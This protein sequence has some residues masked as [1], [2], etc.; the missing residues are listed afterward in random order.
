MSASH[1]SFPIFLQ[2]PSITMSRATTLLFAAAAVAISAIPSS[3]AA[4][5]TLTESYAPNDFLSTSKWS[6]WTDA[7]P[8]NGLVTYQSASNAQSKNLT[9]V[10]ND[11]FYM[12]VDTTQQQLEGRP[13]VRIQSV[14][15][16]SDGIYV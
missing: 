8:T 14:T 2:H 1:P 15:N 16:Y 9:G 5:W 10:S 7:D 11:E 12:R 3:R 13:S 6:Y 4:S